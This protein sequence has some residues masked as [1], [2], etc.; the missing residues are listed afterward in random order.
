MKKSRKAVKSSVLVNVVYCWHILSRCSSQQREDLILLS[1][2]DTIETKLLQYTSKNGL[3]S[4]RKQTG[5][6]GFDPCKLRKG[7]SKS[8]VQ[9]PKD[10]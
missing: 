3:H 2:T 8:T 6:L 5:R 10:A 7:F 4:G 9:L 1:Y